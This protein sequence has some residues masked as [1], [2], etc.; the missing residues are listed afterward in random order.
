MPLTKAQRQH[1]RT[2]AMHLQPV[3]IV[4]NAGVSEAL[5]KE[6]E[7]ALEHHELIKVRVNAADREARDAMIAALVESAGAELVHRIGHVAAIYRRHP[8]KPRI[9]LP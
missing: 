4:G 2:L 8:K 7:I 5:L 6:Y 9:K 1:L 3:I